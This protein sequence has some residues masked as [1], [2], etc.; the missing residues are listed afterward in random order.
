MSVWIG[1]ATPSALVIAIAH[2]LLIFDSAS[3]SFH[4]HDAWAIAQ[5]AL[6]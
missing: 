6:I 4:A 2:I 5:P 1:C 3:S